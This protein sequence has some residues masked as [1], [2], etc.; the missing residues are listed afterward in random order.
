[1]EDLAFLNG[2]RHP[3][4]IRVAHELALSAPPGAAP[5]PVQQ[6]LAHVV[7][8]REQLAYIAAKG[9]A[10]FHVPDWG[11]MLDLLALVL[12]H[13]WFCIGS[14][15]RLSRSRTGPH[16]FG[17]GLQRFIK[18]GRFPPAGLSVLRFL[19][20]V[21][22]LLLGARVLHQ[23]TGTEAQLGRLAGRFDTDRAWRDAAYLCYRSWR[24]DQ[25]DRAGDSERP[26]TSPISLSR[27]D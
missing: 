11:A 2:I 13:S 24:D 8:R 27:R 22:L 16:L 4:L 18:R 25:A 5:T 17:Y 3:D 14:G 15:S 1:V 9:R 19:L 10:S 26:R 12:S 21:A 20:I 23:N 6:A 7:G